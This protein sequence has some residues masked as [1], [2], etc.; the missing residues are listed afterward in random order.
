MHAGGRLQD[1]APEIENEAAGLPECFYVMTKK[2]FFYG[3]VNLCTKISKNFKSGLNSFNL[4]DFTMI[5][6]MLL[7]SAFFVF[8]VSVLCVSFAMSSDPTEIIGPKINAGT[9]IRPRCGNNVTSCGDPGSCVDLTGMVYCVRGRVV[10]SKCLSNNVKNETLTTSCNGGEF[11]IRI[12]NTIGGSGSANVTIYSAGSSSIIGRSSITGEGNINSLDDIVDMEFDLNSS[13]F[14]FLMKNVDLKILNTNRDFVM[15]RLSAVV[16]GAVVFK[17]LYVELPNNFAYSSIIL[18]IKYSDVTISESN[19]TLY[20]CSSFNVTSGTCNSAWQ[21]INLVKDSTRKLA[22]AEV[23]SFSAY[24]LGDSG[25]VTTTTTTTIP[26]S[27]TTTTTTVPNSTTTTTTVSTT[28]TTVYQSDG[29]G[30]QYSTSSI[31]EETDYSDQTDSDLGLDATDESA[32]TNNQTTNGEQQKSANP[33]TALMSMPGN[34]A[35]VIPVVA[36]VTGGLLF[37]L[38]KQGAGKYNKFYY[39]GP[40]K[41]T[42]KSIK[43]SKTRKKTSDIVLNL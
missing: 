23:N 21:K 40:A 16:P 17:A 27:T 24:A 10:R 28:T 4:I 9:G 3:V 33:L 15:E 2:L 14:N 12:K 26:N 39:R 13:Q 8:A 38:S 34:Y 1:E 41:L 22:I 43:H 35:F 36:V 37:G 6:R 29:S 18:K 32:E 25:G 7:A 30:S 11:K 20:K 19:I 31:I 5:K 42:K